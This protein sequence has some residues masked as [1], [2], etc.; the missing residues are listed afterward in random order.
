MN[1]AD[2]RHKLAAQEPLQLGS[3][4]TPIQPLIRLSQWLGGPDIWIKRDDL[5]GVGGGRGW[6]VSHLS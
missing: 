1:G 6:T 5:D 4:P 3:F 2:L